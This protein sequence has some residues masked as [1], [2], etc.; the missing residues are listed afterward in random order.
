MSHPRLEQLFAQWAATWP[1]HSQAALAELCDHALSL[2]EG[3]LDDGATPDEALAAVL[4]ECSDAEIIRIHRGESYQRRVRWTMRWTTA[5]VVGGILVSGS[6]AMWWPGNTPAPLAAT[7]LQAQQAGP[8]GGVPAAGMPGLPIP[9]A[10]DKAAVDS[11]EQNN[12]KTQQKLSTYMAAEFVDTPLN[13]VLQIIGKETETEIYINAK[14]LADESITVDAP[15]TI[16]LKRVRADMLLDLALQQVGNGAVDYI[17]RDGIVVV[18]TV[19]SLDGAS[20]VKA[21]PVAD[22]LKLHGG[23]HQ[24]GAA[25][26]ALGG[27]GPGLMPGAPGGGFGGGGGGGLGGPG[28]DD[29]IRDPENVEQLMNVI[30]STVAPD[31]WQA[32]GGF[33]TVTYY[34][35]MLIVRQNART[36]RE[37]EKLLKL[38]RE[39]AAKK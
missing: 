13:E 26:G 9:P 37:V 5:A 24:P 12:A 18:T 14:P 11:T 23:R 10:A 28:G 38:L 17:V 35:D 39:T 33:G 3:E 4:A 32:S 19:A 34:G 27:P 8:P 36:H 21:Y 7:V 30:T 2:Y 6:I 29:G 25:A 1:R 31:T 20:E 16:D 15:V 22:L